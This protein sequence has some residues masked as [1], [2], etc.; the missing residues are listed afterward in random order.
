MGV[1]GWQDVYKVQSNFPEAVDDSTS[2]KT[3]SLVIDA[4]CE[5]AQGHNLAVLF[6]YCDYQVQK[7]KS[8]ANMLSGLLR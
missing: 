1:K 5:Q 8:A 2:D 7:D 4:L 6:L 3:S